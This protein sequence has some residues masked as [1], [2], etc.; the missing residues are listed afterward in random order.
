M[1]RLS[2]TTKRTKTL[3][4]PPIILS[5]RLQNW[6]CPAWRMPFSPW[7]T[8]KLSCTA[9]GIW[10]YIW[11]SQ[12]LRIRTF[13][14]SGPSLTVFT[15]PWQLC[16]CCAVITIDNPRCCFNRFRLESHDC[17]RFDA[18]STT[19]GYGDLEP[20]TTAGQLF[21][22]V[23]A[24]YGVIILGVF[25]AIF[26]SF[27]SEAQTKAMKRFRKKKQDQMINT[28]FDTGGGAKKEPP[29]EKTG[30]WRDHATL[31]EDIWR[32]IE[33]ELPLI[34]LVGVLALI[35]G[36]REGWG[37]SSRLFTFA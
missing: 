17:F 20:T 23:F 12:S 37:W 8:D 4:V 19:C 31:Y 29:I 36:I 5:Q 6:N 24:I 14:N 7:R 30:F 28:L 2:T 11:Q 3:V 25:I 32:V 16:K 34:A 27:I 22:I 1:P 35:L 18:I 26:G 13:L 33:A 9:F 10:C 15:L 21:T